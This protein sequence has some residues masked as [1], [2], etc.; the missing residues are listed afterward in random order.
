L[1]EDFAYLYP[2][3]NLSDF[4]SYLKYASG[5]E[6]QEE[7]TDEDAVKV[8]TIHASKGMEFPVVFIIDTVERKFPSLDIKD[9]F[10][11]P[12]PLL[13]G[14]QSGLSDKD[15]HIQEERRLMYVA[16]TRAMDKLYLTFA[17]KIKI[18]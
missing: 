5:F 14:L 1:T 4:I 17:K 7:I 9:K 18:I 8:M 10:V 15:L 3:S 13:K 6:I 12:L 2:E 16:L 11:V